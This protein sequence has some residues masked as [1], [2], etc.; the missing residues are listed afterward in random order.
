MRHVFFSSFR[1]PLRDHETAEAAAP[2]DRVVKERRKRG[3]FVAE[4]ANMPPSSR[5]RTRRKEIQPQETSDAEAPDSSPSRP[6]VKKRKVSG[7]HRG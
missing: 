1:G 5:R 6:S 2:F 3:D 4:S 7:G